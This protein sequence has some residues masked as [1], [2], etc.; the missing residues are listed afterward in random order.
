MLTRTELLTLLEISS[1]DLKNRNRRLLVPFE[2]GCGGGPAGP[3]GTAEQ[4]LKIIG[5]AYHRAAAKSG[6]T[7]ASVDDLKEA[8]EPAGAARA[9]QLPAIARVGGMV[10]VLPDASDAEKWDLFGP[11]GLHQWLLLHDLGHRGALVD[12]P[13][14]SI[15]F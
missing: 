13:V 14:G 5:V 1:D 3:A 10:V 7:P 6:N 12:L 4:N 2:S 11:V 8:H 15:R 9:M